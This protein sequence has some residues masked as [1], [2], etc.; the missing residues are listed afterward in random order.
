M[1]SVISKIRPVLLAITVAVTAVTLVVIGRLFNVID[2]LSVGTLIETGETGIA[3]IDATLLIALSNL[4][5]L[6]LSGLVGFGNAVTVEDPP[7]PIIEYVKVRG[8]EV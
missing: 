2:E 6:G 4:I 1:Q 3:V 7:N 5:T 8:Q